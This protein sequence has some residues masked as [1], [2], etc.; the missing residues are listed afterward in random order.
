ML[1]IKIVAIGNLESYFEEAFLEYQKR[2]G[3]F[4]KLQVVQIKPSTIQKE[5]EQIIGY[6]SDKSYN[7]LC[8]LSAKQKTSEQ[9][10]K[11]LESLAQK[12]S[13]I[14][15]IIGGS[16][17]VDQS[18]VNAVDEQLCFSS[19]TFPHQLFRV[20]LIEQ[21]YRAFAINNG[22]KYHK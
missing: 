13:Q 22:Q 7:I 4:C 17:G 12:H 3:K 19:M 6:I 1:S 16:D 2:L 5:S 20:M 14:T 15:F 11:M 9:L 8:S 18:V 21:I 10:A